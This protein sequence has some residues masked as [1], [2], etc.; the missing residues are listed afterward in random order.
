[1][2]AIELTAILMLIRNMWSVWSFGMQCIS[3]TR[4]F[5]IIDSTDQNKTGLLDR[6]HNEH[7]I[8]RNKHEVNERSKYVQTS[9]SYCGD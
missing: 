1:M 8:C 4:R 7:V 2:K 6:L 5:P 3:Q 9:S